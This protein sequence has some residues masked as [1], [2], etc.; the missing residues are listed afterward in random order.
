MYKYFVGDTKGWVEVKK[1][2][3]VGAN[4]LDFISTSSYAKGKY[5]YL[6]EDVDL[7][8]FVDFLGYLPSLS[9][10]KVKDNHFENYKKYKGGLQ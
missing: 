4:L 6:D 2:E 7:S 5:V 8:F 9:V 10:V 1:A 3:L